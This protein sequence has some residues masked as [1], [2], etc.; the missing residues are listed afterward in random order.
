[1]LAAEQAI[2]DSL[3]VDY[4]FQ[5]PVP[6]QKAVKLKDL[7]VAHFAFLRLVELAAQKEDG[8]VAAAAAKTLLERQYGKPKQAIDVNAERGMEIVIKA[9]QPGKGEQGESE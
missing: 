3:K 9:M 6:G 8:A 1:M 7:S 5:P 2:I 4:E